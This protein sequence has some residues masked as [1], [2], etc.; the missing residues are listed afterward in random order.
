VWEHRRDSESVLSRGDV[1][2][3]VV[4]VHVRQA[5]ACIGEAQP[6]ARGYLAVSR[7]SI[8]VHCDVNV[9]VSNC[10]MDGYAPARLRQEA[11]A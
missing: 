6:L 3:K 5:G 10:R 8:V 4:A 1:E 9:A 2:R 7:A 11:V